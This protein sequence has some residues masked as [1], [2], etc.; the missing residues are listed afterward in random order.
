M[1]EPFVHL[2]VHTAYSL[3]DGAIKL[4]DLFAKAKQDGQQ[5]VAITDHGNLHGVVQFY[6]QAKANGIKPIIGCEVYVA[7]GS[8]TD[9][10]PNQPKPY[11][12]VLLCENET[13]YQNLL[14]LVNLAHLEGKYYRPRIDLENLAKYHEGLIALSSCLAGMLPRA[15]MDGGVKKARETIDWY[16]QVFGDRFYLEIQQ[17]GLKEQDKVNAAVQKLSREFDIPLVATCDAHYL[18]REDAL[19]HEILLCIQTGKTMQDENRMRFSTDQVYFR[20]ADE[21]AE[22]FAD[23]PEAVRNTL[24]VAER[25]NLELK[26]GKLIFPTYEAPE[27]EDLD[28]TFA[29]LSRAGLDRRLTVLKEEYQ[30]AG[31]GTWAE[32]EKTYHDRLEHEIK[33][34]RDK[35]YAGYFLI[36]QDFIGWAR[37]RGIPV[38]PGRGSAAGSLASYSLGITNIDPIRY[39]LLFERFLNPERQDNPD[40]DIDFCTDRRGEVIQYVA[41][42]YG[43][44]KV[45]Q[46]A[47]FGT[48]KAKLV[49]KDVGRAMGY[50]YNEVESVAKLIPNDL[51]M[52]L[53]KAEKTPDLEKLLKQSDWV[54]ELWRNAR[55]L[56]GLLRHA[57]THAAGVVISNR[58]LSET[59]PL[60]LDKDDH[61]VTQLDKDDVE[62]VGLIKFDFLGLKTLTVIDKALAIIKQV[63]RKEIDIDRLP[64]DD[65]EAFG[66]LGRGLTYGV[67]Q[68]E[69]SG[70]KDL[71]VQIQPNSIEDLTA[72]AALYRPGPL[73]SGMIPDFIARKKGAAVKYL[74]NELEQILKPTY[75]MIVYQ[76]QVQQVAHQIGGL[77]MGEA[78]LMRR[79]MAK[80]K[81]DKMA[82][83]K[84]KFTAGA[85]ERGHQKEKIE[86]LW[87][88][89]EKFAEYGFNKSHS[90]AYALV[91]YQ[92]AYL[93]AHYPAA[94][95]AALMTMDRGDSD[96]IMGGIVECRELGLEVLPPD[97][98]ESDE[99]FTVTQYG[100]IRF[101]LTAVKNVGEGAVQCIIKA[102]QGGGDFRSLHDFAERVDLHKINKRVV[103]SL[104]KCGAFDSLE[105]N[106]AA[107]LAAVDKAV[108]AAVKTQADRDTGQTSLFGRLS[109]T[110]KQAAP[111][112]PDVP[113][114]PHLEMLR[115]EKEALGFFI[116]GHPLDDHQTIIQRFATLN[117]S[118]LREQTTN[119]EVR[120]AAL[121]TSFT[122]RM[123]KQN[124][125]MA[126]GIAE[127][128]Y[129]PFGITMF[130]EAMDLSVEALADLD[131]P[132]LLFGKVDLRE[133]DNGLLVD[134]A[135]PLVKAPELC[136]NEAHIHL[137]TVG[138]TKMQI[139]R[140]ADCI[141]R[142][143]G[144]CRTVI[145]LMIPGCGETVFTLPA[146]NGLKPSDELIDE[147]RAIFGAAVLTFQ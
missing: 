146:H 127:D 38:G 5:A 79:A 143:V 103:E 101:G 30:A 2:H 123:T 129:A 46:I 45:A 15:I 74:L 57:S 76:E 142:N 16:R 128:Q 95:M 59:V 55:V 121:I 132:V 144:G 147:V 12:Q 88:Q 102:R 139:Q 36:V 54:R 53:E 117:S 90:A 66:L 104:V 138:L 108:D 64:L 62:A 80:K 33:L 118:G 140:L 137:G 39:N 18:N 120:I 141:K 19:P 10:S 6:K 81:A 113:A 43:K 91:A 14:R 60:M 69:S 130:S 40:I 82:P 22:A 20:T 70:M 35:E 107:L 135:I 42:K 24:E 126:R 11:H 47:T 94:F 31:N 109:G 13:G 61:V 119:R 93:K 110:G 48:M 8:L 105:K 49:I 77:S 21:M 68:F 122:K 84:V 73:G 114:W 85:K 136:S 51:K 26:L 63:Q 111:Q 9:K 71:L 52:T 134:K 124:K 92:T 131:Q 133:G 27:G 89:L 37:S 100:Q 29:R 58:P 106:R 4:P 99:N 56:E 67:F 78:D 23:T 41:E 87:D 65:A 34:I 44:D 125:P 96:K 75:G 17:N 7:T 72:I 3:L 1:A 50:S 116:S 83:F 115:N 98:N 86:E 145:H 32:V 112:L 25:C 97:I 28:A